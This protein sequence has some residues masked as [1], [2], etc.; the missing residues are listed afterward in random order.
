MKKEQLIAENAKLRKSHEEWV[1]GDVR[2]RK[3]F[4]KAFN[5]YL[6]KLYH[7]DETEYRTPSWEEI[8]IEIGSLLHAKG[9]LSDT[10]RLEALENSVQELWNEKQDDPTSTPIT[11]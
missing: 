9:M 7:G 5:W 8:F 1:E 6:K 3:E 10:R 2:R 4:A 11:P